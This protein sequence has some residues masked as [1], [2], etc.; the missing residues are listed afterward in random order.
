MQVAANLNFEVD[1]FSAFATPPFLLGFGCPN[2][3]RKIALFKLFI[4][5][6][7]SRRRRPHPPLQPV[8]IRNLVGEKDCDC[9]HYELALH[10]GVLPVTDHGIRG[11][12]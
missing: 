10:C 2:S 12:G 3:L 9:S 6:E 8:T 11:Y 4:H 7:S 1:A 5:R